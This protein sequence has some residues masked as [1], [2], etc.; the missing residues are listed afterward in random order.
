MTIPRFQAADGRLLM[1]ETIDRRNEKH[2]IGH[3]HETSP[4]TP[5]DL[6]PLLAP[7]PRDAPH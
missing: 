5:L 7:A 1:L 3:D 4:L 6:P 2:S